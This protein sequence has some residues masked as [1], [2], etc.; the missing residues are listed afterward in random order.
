MSPTNAP[1][2][3]KDQPADGTP[4]SG[5]KQDYH[6][7]MP[8][9]EI[10]RRARE[11]FGQS[12]ADVENAI[13][14]RAI[15]IDAIEKSQYDKLPGRV[16]A[17]GF[18]RSY[19]EYLGFEGDKMVALFKTQSAGGGRIKPELNFPAPASESRLPPVGLVIAG[20]ALFIAFIV[21]WASGS[22]TD[23]EK[24]AEIP[25]VSSVPD[26]APPGAAADVTEPPADEV[27]AAP[28][29]SPAA[30]PAAPAGG[31]SAVIP[32]KAGAVPAAE[33]Q[34]EQPEEED[35][36]PPEE[37]D[38]APPAVPA[39]EKPAAAELPPAKT[40]DAS[41]PAAAPASAQDGI[42]LNVKEN[43]WVEIRDQSGKA[44]VSRMLK[45]GDQYFVPNRPDLIMSLGNAG[46]IEGMMDGKPLPP[47]GK[48]GEV[49]RNI[50]LDTKAL[51]A[52]AAGR[53]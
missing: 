4:P 18:V 38:A 1:K 25:P 16:Y 2:H 26:P 33:A 8:V 35:V 43:S 13:R 47:F 6:T 53:E 41:E 7:N 12:L 24:V 3:D 31:P 50:S 29:A 19:S 52:L 49:R 27:A 20:L 48:K 51:K 42:T 34:A 22:T 10:L 17:I 32:M 30:A 40:A 46:G 5:K 14:I 23:V 21:V 39:A 44:I 9:G 11:H 36:A 45:T 37:P 28:E 15:Q